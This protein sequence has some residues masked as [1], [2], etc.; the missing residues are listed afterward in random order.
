MKTFT[1]YLPDDDYYMLRERHPNFLARMI[2]NSHEDVQHRQLGRRYNR[3]PEVY[4]A[5]LKEIL[6]EEHVYEEPSPVD[7]L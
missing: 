1:L 2:A 3:V 4:V 7:S 6:G 5:R